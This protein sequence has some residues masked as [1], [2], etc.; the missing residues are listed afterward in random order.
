MIQDTPQW[1]LQHLLNQ[2]IELES[3][4]TSAYF[5]FNRGSDGEIESAIR[6]KDLLAIN[7]KE[8]ED[9]LLEIDQEKA[10]ALHRWLS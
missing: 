8:I 9:T 7:K 2:K 1:R 5:S 10:S 6:I 3:K 4:Q